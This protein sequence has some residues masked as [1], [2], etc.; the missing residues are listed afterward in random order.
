MVTIFFGMPI[1]YV[2][3]TKNELIRTTASG[4]LTDADLVQFKRALA[5]DPLFHAGL[6][7]ISDV[8]AVTDLSVTS[9][10]VRELVKQ[11]ANQALRRNVHR[12]AIVTGHDLTFGTAR[13]YQGL[14]S[15]NMPGV[16][17]F[18][19]YDQAVRW[20]GAEAAES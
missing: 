19:D 12:L 16:G 13:M 9:D 4:V 1:R 6:R 10:G 8:R 18:K 2:I 14:T 17:V 20:L 5:A 11:D 3:D 15:Q 7:E